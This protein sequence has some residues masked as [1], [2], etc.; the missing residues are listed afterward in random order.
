MK[1]RDTNLREGVREEEREGGRGGGREGGR[2]EAGRCSH[3]HVNI[4]S[5]QLCFSDEVGG[6][7]CN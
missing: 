4:K 6:V 3:S 2:I 5:F 1:E 7:S